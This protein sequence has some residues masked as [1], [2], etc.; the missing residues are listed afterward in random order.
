MSVSLPNL[1][2]IAIAIHPKIP[3]AA[4]RAGEI[5]AYLKEQG[6]ETVLGMLY[7]EELTR[8]IKSGQFD[9]MIALG[10]D[11]TMLRAGHL[12]GP[13]KLPILGINLGRFGFL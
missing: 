13:S 8:Q 12:C 7:D 2:N 6:I 5:E 1:Q 10:G 3:Q 4:A 9:L 11:G